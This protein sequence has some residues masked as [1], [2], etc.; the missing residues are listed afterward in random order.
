MDTFATFFHLEL[1]HA[2][3]PDGLCRDIAVSVHPDT[4]QW[5]AR[6]NVRFHSGKAN[7]WYLTGDTSRLKGEDALLRFSLVC[8]NPHFLYHTARG[9][10]DSENVFA[11]YVSP[12]KAAQLHLPEK[13]TRTEP[14]EFPGEIGR[15]YLALNGNL[16]QAGYTEA[17]VFFSA[18]EQ[19]WEYVFIPRN[20]NTNRSLSLEE[21]NN[22]IT[23]TPMKIYEYRGV[24]GWTCQSETRVALQERYDYQLRLA[25]ITPFGQKT[26]VSRLPH[27]VPG[28]FTD[29]TEGFIREVIYF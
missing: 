9:G 29:A 10:F 16:P 7:E 6:R 12:G 14:Q 15:V 5:L 2:Y 18:S 19:A 27:P 8:R 28:R 25:E 24:T 20:G 1:K 26:L 23:F 17:S 3:Y 13:V 21:R 11:W 4:R 22:K